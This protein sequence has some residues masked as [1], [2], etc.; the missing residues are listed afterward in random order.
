MAIISKVGINTGSSIYYSMNRLTGGLRAEHTAPEVRC[1]K[2]GTTVVRRPG[3]KI[4]VPAKNSKL[5]KMG[6]TAITCFSKGY[7]PH[8]G[9]LIS[10]DLQ[11]SKQSAGLF[12]PKEAANFLRQLK[13]LQQELTTGV[14][15]STE[16]LKKCV[17]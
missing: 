8:S 5:G 4:V 11:G 16:K 17:L 3:I 10:I 14:K 2:S 6:V 15:N 1:F 9:K 7:F 13:E 12:T